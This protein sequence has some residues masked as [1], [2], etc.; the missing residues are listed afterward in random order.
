MASWQKTVLTVVVA[1]LGAV[2]LLTWG[3]VGSALIGL[4]LII[5]GGALLYQKLI[6]NR[7]EDDYWAG[8]EE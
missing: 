5:M 3:S 8:T 7:D 1:V 6:T 4:C 2:M